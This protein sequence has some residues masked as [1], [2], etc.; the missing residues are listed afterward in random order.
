LVAFPP[1]NVKLV[2]ATSVEVAIFQKVDVLPVVAV[3]NVC[4]DVHVASG[5]VIAV[6]LLKP[7]CAII[8]LP[9]AKLVGLTIT[10]V[11]LVAP[12]L[13]PNSI[14]ATAIGSLNNLKHH[15]ITS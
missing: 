15:L 7:T 6:V 13:T 3:A 10:Q 8:K 12:G 9:I 2:A 14:K 1:V 5:A 4:M 11:V